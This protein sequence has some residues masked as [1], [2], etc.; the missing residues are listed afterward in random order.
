MIA[1]YAQ[2]GHGEEA[3]KLFQQMQLAGVKPTQKPLPVFS[4]HV[5][6]WQLWNRVWRSMKK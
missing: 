2:N 3:L 5:P 4:Q 1:G 6:T